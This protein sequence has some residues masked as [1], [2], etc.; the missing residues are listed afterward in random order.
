MSHCL[1]DEQ[2]SELQE[3]LCF[4]SLGRGLAKERGQEPS[5][6]SV[7]SPIPVGGLIAPFGQ[8]YRLPFILRSLLQPERATK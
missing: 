8:S 4:Q 6:R 7:L 1:A 2:R 3:R 5:E